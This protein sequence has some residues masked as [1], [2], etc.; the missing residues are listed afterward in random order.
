MS[1]FCSI[2]V[3]VT[4]L[5]LL[6]CMII[7]CLLFRHL[8]SH[9]LFDNWVQ[10]CV[11]LRIQIIMIKFWNY[12]KISMLMGSPTL[13]HKQYSN[14]FIQDKPFSNCDKGCSKFIFHSFW[15]QVTI[16]VTI[17]E[18]IRLIFMKKIRK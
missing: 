6:S 13:S 12:L 4:N 10:N 3:R 11:E 18:Q 2:Q 17:F 14:I 8:S 1:L 16:V 5:R 15:D 9:H 7:H